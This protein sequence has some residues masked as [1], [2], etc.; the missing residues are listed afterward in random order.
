MII[1]KMKNSGKRAKEVKERNWGD[2]VKKKPGKTHHINELNILNAIACKNIHVVFEQGCNGTSN[3]INTN[4][5]T[6]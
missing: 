3:N 6:I 2:G 4:K 5:F 1:V